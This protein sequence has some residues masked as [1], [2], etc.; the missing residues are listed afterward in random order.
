MLLHMSTGKSKGDVA[1]T[2]VKSA[3]IWLIRDFMFENARVYSS[4]LS[5][6][7]MSAPE[8]RVLAN[9]H[10]RCPV[11]GLEKASL[12]IAGSKKSGRVLGGA[13]IS[14]DAEFEKGFDTKRKLS[15]LQLFVK[16]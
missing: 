16:L 2:L 5:K 11:A 10:S 14:F 1:V 7:S 4:T 13:I 3:E 12:M 15:V 9:W 8:F 6:N